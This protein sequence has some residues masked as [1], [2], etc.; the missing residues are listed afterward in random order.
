MGRRVYRSAAAIINTTE[1]MR[2]YV[3]V[4]PCERRRVSVDGLSFLCMGYMCVCV[5]AMV[6][7]PES[8]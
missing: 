4:R 8:A 1:R 2:V 5:R 6:T 7:R 3:C